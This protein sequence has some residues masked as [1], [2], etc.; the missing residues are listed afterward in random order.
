MT[1]L[2]AA[3]ITALVH[4]DLRAEWRSGEVV[5]TTVPFAATG[6]LVIALAVGAD[7]P[8]LRRIGAGLYWAVVVLLGSLIP[9]RQTS[10][11][12][13]AR[14]DLLRLLGID[15]V[16]SYLSRTASTAVLIAVLEMVLAPVVVVLYDL[17]LQAALAS[18]A[19]G[20]AVAVGLAA[21]GTL[22]ADLTTMPGPRTSLV[23]LIIAPLAVP[24]VLAA[25]QVH[26][27]ATYGTSPLGWLLIALIVAVVAVLAGVLAARHLQEEHS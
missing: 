6:L 4:A 22:A 9:L 2:P 23:P 21:L 16:V 24:L 11:D 1:P 14:R 10:H 19:A 3:Q 13:P 27:G 26:E 17:T 18:A 12:A 15:P 25:V 8:L 7:A 5:W 20:L